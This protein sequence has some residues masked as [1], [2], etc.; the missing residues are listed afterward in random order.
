MLNR[1]RLN[2]DFIHQEQA[3]SQLLLRPPLLSS[4]QLGWRGIMLQHHLQLP[5][6]MPESEAAQHAIVVHWQYNNVHVDRVI[7]ETKQRESINDGDCL[8]VPAMASHKSNWDRE[9]EFTLMILEPSY[10]NQ[11][12]HETVDGDRVE[13]MPQFAKPDPI[14]ASIATALKTELES[15]GIGGKFYVES[16]ITF[17]AAH[18]LQHHC[19]RTQL[20]KNYG[21][22]L[23]KYRFREAIAYI[24]EHLSEEISLEAIAN[25]L[26]ISQHYFC[27]L[28]KQ[29]M[30]ISPYQYVLRQRIEKAKQLLKQ[31]KLTIV[32]VA[33]ECGFANQTHFTKHF[34][35]LT[36]TTPRAY[37]EQ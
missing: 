5:G 32:D 26:H 13:L 10:L 23:P 27:H 17:L 16:A 20:F 18:L 2:I 37:R 25:H 4:E 21:D 29:S 19:S 22:G 35:K 12:A 36:G 33:M 6:E 11:I 7:D 34:R 30:G 9:V 3:S 1:S 28:F 14:I 15:D 31:R 8:I 24:N